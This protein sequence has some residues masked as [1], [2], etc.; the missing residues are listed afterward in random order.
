MSIPSQFLYLSHTEK[1]GYIWK[2]RFG[3]KTVFISLKTRVL[4]VAQQRAAS[5]TGKMVMMRKFSLTTD[6]LKQVLRRHRDELVDAA[7]LESLTVQNYTIEHHPV[8]VAP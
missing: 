3:E 4:S 5:I 6:A 8:S 1:D 7:L 2:K